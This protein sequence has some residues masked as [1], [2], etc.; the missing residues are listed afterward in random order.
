M[1]LDPGPQ[2][3]RPDAEGAE[4]RRPLDG[5]E[6]VLGYEF[7]NKRLLATALVHKSYL[8]DVPRTGLEPN[9]RL[10]FL[11]DAVLD[12]IVSANLYVLNPGMSEGQLSALRGALV[13]MSTLAEIAAPL[14][15]GE[16]MYMSR[17]EE[18]AGGRTRD[19][20]TGRAVEAVLGAAF[21]D[22][23]LDAAT[24]VWRQMGGERGI[25]QLEAVLSTDY[26]SQLQQFVQAMYRLT[27]SYR[28]VETTGPE[29]E[30]IFKVEVLAGEE[31][32]AYGMGRNK[33]TAEQDAAKAALSR[34]KVVA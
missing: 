9:E 32:L 5:L 6:A 18:A 15:L 17:G 22:G 30:K 19:S 3:P 16:Y 23:G 31:V 34:L 24:H 4:P 26:K 13:R 21:L 28:T 10:E 11:G 29:H 25:E 8:H 2:E 33:Q 1:T 12:L 20:N 27:P 14:E 7:K